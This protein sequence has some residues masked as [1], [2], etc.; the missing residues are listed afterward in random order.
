MLQRTE[1]VLIA[2]EKDGYFFWRTRNFKEVFFE[3]NS[4]DSIGD[5][6][7]IRITK[8]DRY[9]LHWEKI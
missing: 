5:I 2:W 6:I 9:V 3:K 1:P 7:D 4:S 8:L